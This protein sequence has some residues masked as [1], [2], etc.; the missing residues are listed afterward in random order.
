MDALERYIT[1]L[2]EDA[3]R[4]AEVGASVDGARL[5]RKIAGRLEAIQRERML[6]TL[7]LSEA[8]AERGIAY[9]TMQRKVASGEVPNVGDKN[10]PR[11]RRCD[12][13][14]S[15]TGGPD[16]AGKVLRAHPD[17]A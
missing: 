15:P 16:I 1:E 10:R 7:S 8:A 5:C 17:A 6:E 2:R 4:Y 9:G 12:L 11:V 14:N 13:L 3:E